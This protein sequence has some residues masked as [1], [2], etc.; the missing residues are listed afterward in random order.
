MYRVGQGFDFRRNKFEYQP[1][2][3]SEKGFSYISEIYEDKLK[4]TRFKY[5]YRMNY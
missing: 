3:A 5:V 1:I 2:K 4:L